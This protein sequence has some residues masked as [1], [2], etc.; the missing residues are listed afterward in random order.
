[1]SGYTQQKCLRLLKKFLLDRTYKRQSKD[2][3]QSQ[4]VIGCTD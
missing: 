1:M 2:I 3:F 4:L